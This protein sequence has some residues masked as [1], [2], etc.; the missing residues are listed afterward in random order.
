MCDEHGFDGWEVDP[1]LDDYGTDSVHDYDD[2]G[3]FG[4]GGFDEVVA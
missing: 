3:E 1:V 4:G 2:C